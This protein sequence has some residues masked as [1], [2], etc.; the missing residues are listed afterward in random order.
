[1]KKKSKLFTLI[2]SALFLVA[3]ITVYADEIF[4]YQ[5]VDE[6][7]LNPNT[8]PPCM[9]CINTLG[10]YYCML[11]DP[12]CTDHDHSPSGNVVLWHR[13]DL[14]C[15][16]LFTGQRSGTASVGIPGF[17]ATTISFD[18]EGNCKVTVKYGRTTCT[19][20]GHEQCVARYCGM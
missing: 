9:M 12:S 10:A 1:M 13:N 7:A 16:Y 5:D 8:C 20:G 4:E 3:G 2:L 14:D 18:K 17:G 11:M 6:C 15:E 19:S